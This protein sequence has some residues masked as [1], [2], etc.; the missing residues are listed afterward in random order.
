MIEDIRM[1]RSQLGELTPNLEPST[2][3]V[4][5]AAYRVNQ[6]VGQLDAQCGQLMM[7]AGRL[8]GSS[9]RGHDVVSPDRPMGPDFDD[10]DA[11][12]Q[13]AVDRVSMLDQLIKLFHGI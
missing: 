6:I 7:I 4:R 9:E 13:N 1:K 3:R 5:E 12:I 8:F 2:G 11:A 10:L